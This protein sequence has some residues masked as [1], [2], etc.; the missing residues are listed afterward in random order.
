MWECL[1]DGSKVLNKIYQL[2][3]HPVPFLNLLGGWCGGGGGG[4]GGE[5]KTSMTVSVLNYMKQTRLK[6][7]N[8]KQG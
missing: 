1:V 7:K 3:G 8:D 5:P 2:N 4:G 6:K